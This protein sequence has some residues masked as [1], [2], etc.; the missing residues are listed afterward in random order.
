MRVFRVSPTQPSPLRT[1]FMSSFSNGSNPTTAGSLRCLSETSHGHGRALSAPTHSIPCTDPNC[2]QLECLSDIDCSCLKLT[3]PT[4]D[5]TPQ[6]PPAPPHDERTSTPQQVEFRRE[7]FA[8]SRDACPY[9]CICI[10]HFF[11]EDHWQRAEA[12]AQ[13]FDGADPDLAILDRQ[14]Q[15]QRDSEEYANDDNNNGVD[16]LAATLGSSQPN[17]GPPWHWDDN[18]YKC[19]ICTRQPPV[20]PRHILRCTHLFCKECLRDSVAATILLGV[21]PVFFPVCQAQAQ[22]G[23]TSNLSESFLLSVQRERG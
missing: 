14:A 20:D 22:G 1:D 7:D 21:F 13:L 12:H 17:L 8:R 11:L 5:D 16:S 2:L 10:C 3:T 6:H 15:V 4:F 18:L 23:D 19:A 9:N